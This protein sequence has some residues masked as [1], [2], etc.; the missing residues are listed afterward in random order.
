[1]GRQV[2]LPAQADPENPAE[3][4]ID[5]VETALA[6]ESRPLQEADGGRRALAG[7][8]P[9]GRRLA[10]AQLRRHF[11]E[12]LGLDPLRRREK[13]HRHSALM[14][15]SRATLD[16]FTSSAEMKPPNSAGVIR[17]TSAPSV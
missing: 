2:D 11:G 5:D 12:H 7:G 6:V 17:T 3:R 8:E 4:G 14:P 15:T 9:L 1:I 10:F 13:A 16:H